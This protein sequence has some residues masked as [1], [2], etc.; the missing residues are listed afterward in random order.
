[1]D[2]VYV[3][4]AHNKYNRFVQGTKFFFFFESQN[5]EYFVYALRFFWQ[6]YL[7]AV[8]ENFYNA[9]ELKIM[10]LAKDRIIKTRKNQ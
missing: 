1:M 6:T 9:F 3:D 4:C 8:N 10:T 5:G 2:D 7:K